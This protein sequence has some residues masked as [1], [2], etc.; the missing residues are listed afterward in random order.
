MA[1]TPREIEDR[2]EEAALT[3]RRLPTKD[4][5]RRYGSSWPE[6]VRDARHAYG[7]HD[8]RIRIVPSAAEI[9]RMEEVLGWMKLIDDPVDR[10]IVWMRAENYPWRA[11]CREA[12]C[13]RST[14]WRRWAAALLTIAKRLKK[15][16]RAR[17]TASNRKARPAPPATLPLAPSE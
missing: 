4:G 13:V 12:G 16:A 17:K 14:A 7:Y 5:P 10:R 6:F 2:F 11:V 15:Q 1:L 8:V 9:Q 3:L